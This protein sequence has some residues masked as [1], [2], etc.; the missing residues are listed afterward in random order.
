MGPPLRLAPVLYGNVPV[1]PA[2][3]GS[4]IFSPNL[5]TSYHPLDG[6]SPASDIQSLTLSKRFHDASGSGPARAQTA[7]SLGRGATHQLSRSR[8]SGRTM[9]L[10]SAPFRAALSCRDGVSGLHPIS[11][12]V[13][14]LRPFAMLQPA[15]W[16]SPPRPAMAA[17]CPFLWWTPAAGAAR[18]RPP[19]RHR[20]RHILCPE[21][22]ASGSPPCCQISFYD[23]SFGFCYNVNKW[24]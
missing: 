15:A 22:L 19:R 16:Y 21:R 2:H 14:A 13:G 17:R 3:P 9:R 24:I 20:H 6:M 1:I 12:P 4:A 11:A 10:S 23:S 8:F 5:P 18:L 7:P